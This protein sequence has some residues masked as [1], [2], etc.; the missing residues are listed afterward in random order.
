MRGCGWVVVGLPLRRL[1]VTSPGGAEGQRGRR[2]V[3]DF[4]VRG[5]I[6]LDLVGDLKSKSYVREM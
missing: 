3:G 2:H 4:S 1:V 6:V 5:P